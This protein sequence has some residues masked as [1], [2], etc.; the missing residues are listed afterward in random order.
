MFSA[1]GSGRC[2]VADAAALASVSQCII[3]GKEGRAVCGR[4]RMVIL[5]YF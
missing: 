5:P 4:D 3:T 2:T 1:R